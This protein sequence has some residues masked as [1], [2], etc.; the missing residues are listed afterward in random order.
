MVKRHVNRRK[1]GC[2][3]RCKLRRNGASQLPEQPQESRTSN[4]LHVLLKEYN[5]GRG[6]SGRGGLNKSHVKVWDKPS[7]YG[8]D[9]EHS[10]MSPGK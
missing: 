10:F 6:V 9:L 4:Q 7:T 8:T 3:G 1:S 5:P 2:G